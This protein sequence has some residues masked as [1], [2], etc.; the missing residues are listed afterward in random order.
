MLI[1]KDILLLIFLNGNIRLF[2]SASAYKK[3]KVV[4]KHLS[5][6]M[7]AFYLVFLLNIYYT[8][9]GRL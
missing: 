4:L 7:D 6:L 5:C 8:E 1:N 2:R 9:N 3:I